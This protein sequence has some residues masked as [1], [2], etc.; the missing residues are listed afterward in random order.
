MGHTLAETEGF[1]ACWDISESG[2]EDAAIRCMTPNWGPEQDTVVRA[3]AGAELGSGDPSALREK[4]A[5]TAQD[6]EQ[7]PRGSRH[8]QKKARGPPQHPVTHLPLEF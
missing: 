4:P 8:A 5:Q 3:E 6:K 7:I 2:Q 1:R